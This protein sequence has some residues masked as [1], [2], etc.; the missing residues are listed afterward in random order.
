[1]SKIYVNTKANYPSLYV[2]FQKENSRRG[3]GSLNIRQPVRY[4]TFLHASLF[5]YFYV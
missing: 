3:N 1:M 2:L 5:N 4:Y